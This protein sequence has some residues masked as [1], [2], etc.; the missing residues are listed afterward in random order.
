M[1]DWFFQQSIVLSLLILLLAIIYRVA[2]STIGAKNYYCL[3]L[4][5]PTQLILSL[6]IQDAAL[7]NDAQVSTYVV[8][9]NNTVNTLQQ[10]IISQLPNITIFWGAGFC[11]FSGLLLT[12]HYHAIKQ[13][14][15]RPV[16]NDNYTEMSGDRIRVFESSML[17]SP[18]ITGLIFPKIVLPIGFSAHPRLIQKLLFKHELVHFQRGDLWWNTL[19]VALLLAFWFN[20]IMWFG[21]RRFRQTQELACDSQVL[22]DQSEETCLSYAKAFLEQSFVQQR[23]TFTSLYYGGKQNMKDRIKNMRTRHHSKLLLPPLLAVLISTLGISQAISGNH[24]QQD[25]KFIDGVHPTMRI[26]PLYPKEAAE[27][28]IEGSVVLQFS[29]NTDGSVGDIHIVKSTPENVFDKSAMTALS[30]W[31]YTRPNVK[32]KNMLVQLDYLLSEKSSKNLLSN[33]EQISVAP[34][35]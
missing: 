26:E 19:A 32:M 29:I 27:Q 16:S 35:K 24:A 2:L 5:I 12:Q 11:L 23:M 34:R 31:T 18:M 3:W 13:L 17:N 1:I 22:K 14:R 10:S 15:I 6:T 21:Y 30:Q 7:I 9:A 25:K 33:L 4:I 8:S 28:G 20:P